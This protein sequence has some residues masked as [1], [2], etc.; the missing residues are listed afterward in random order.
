LY[1]VGNVRVSGARVG[2]IHPAVPLPDVL[3]PLFLKVNPG[4]QGHPVL[5]YKV[6]LQLFPL[7]VREVA[8]NHGYIWGWGVI[9]LHR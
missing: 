3:N 7:V 2:P 8:L 5:V 6:V 9:H 1:E 4:I